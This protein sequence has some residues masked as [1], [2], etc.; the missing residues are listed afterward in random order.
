MTPLDIG[1]WVRQTMGGSLL[2]ALPVAVLATG[3]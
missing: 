3:R 1:E 2:V